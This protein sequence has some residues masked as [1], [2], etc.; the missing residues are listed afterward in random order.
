MYAPVG[1]F[2]V[3]FRIIKYEVTWHNINDVNRTTCIPVRFAVYL[4]NFL[5]LNG[6]SWCK[7]NCY[8]EDPFQT[9]PLLLQLLKS[10]ARTL[11]QDHSRLHKLFKVL[12]L[13]HYSVS[14]T[15]VFLQTER[16]AKVE[17][18]CRYLRSL[19]TV[20]LIPSFNF[21]GSAGRRFFPFSSR[22]FPLP[23][24]PPCTSGSSF[25]KT[26]ALQATKLLVNIKAKKN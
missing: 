18:N 19:I 16:R 1:A 7:T 3:S 11:F 25:K 23:A 9:H 8:T 17:T 12:A 15:L 4:Q 6:M 13:Q 2:Q 21:I 5:S 22:P 10:E 14:K 26:P 24:P 20:M